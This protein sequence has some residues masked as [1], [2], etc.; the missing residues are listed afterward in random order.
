MDHEHGEM[1][2]YYGKTFQNNQGELTEM[3]KHLLIIFADGCTTKK[4]ELLQQILH[5]CELTRIA[6]FAHNDMGMFVQHPRF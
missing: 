3:L 2:R 5:H 4:S 6:V 1:H